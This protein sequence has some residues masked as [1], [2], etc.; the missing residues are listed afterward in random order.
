MDA[1]SMKKT[2]R[3][4]I[5]NLENAAENSLPNHIFIK[6]GRKTVENFRKIKQGECL[7]NYRGCMRLKYDKPSLVVRGNSGTHYI[8]PV[9][10]RM[11]THREMARL[12]SFPDNFIFKGGSQYISTQIG[13]AVPPL[14]AEGIASGIKQMLNLNI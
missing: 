1:S 13:N 7:Y 2:T 14:M 10:H 5:E 12:Q 6:H 4:V 3:D 11:L 8:H 9:L